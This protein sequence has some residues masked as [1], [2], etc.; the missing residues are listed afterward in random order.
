MQ[1][2]HGLTSARQNP[3]AARPAIGAHA[4]RPAAAE[5]AGKRRRWRRRDIPAVGAQSPRSKVGGR[6][7]GGGPGAAAQEGSGPGGGGSG[8]GA[9]SGRGA[10]SGRCASSGIKMRVG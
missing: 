3:S 8:R 4:R 9:A 7:R 5:G 2:F 10:M 6:R 1:E